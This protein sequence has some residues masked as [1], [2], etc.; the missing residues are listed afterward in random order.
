M[1]EAATKETTSPPVTTAPPSNKPT[2]CIWHKGCLDGFTSAWV[3]KKFFGNRVEFFA[4]AY[5]EPP[6]DV[7]GRNVLMVDFSYKKR[8]I[9]QLRSF[10]RAIL[11]LDHHKTAEADLAEYHPPADTVKGFPHFPDTGQCIAFFDMQRSGAALCW[12]FFFP[13]QP[14]PKLVQHVQ[15][16]DLWLFTLPGTREINT[17]AYSHD[18]TFEAWDNL[19]TLCEQP[20]TFQNL[21]QQGGGLM[22]QRLKDCTALIEE[23]RR[24]MTIAGQDIFVVN[25]P[26]FYASE[27]GNLL[28]TEYK[29]G[30]TYYDRKDDKRVFS[31]RSVPDGPDVSEIAQQ[32]G[33]GG[34][35]NAAGFS[36]PR[37]WE[38]DT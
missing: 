6:P 29:V 25:A 26:W 23:G 34:H 28:A 32:Y 12:D 31:L 35:R 16:R 11:I 24:A 14:M 33:G 2:L 15:D 10:A 38:G 1:A 13:A 17:L 3:V 21:V 27:I 8:Q 30:G 9:E 36:R 20:G 37:N 4:G 19:A 7:R 5:G 22:R 18:F